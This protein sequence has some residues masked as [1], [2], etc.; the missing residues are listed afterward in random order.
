LI[1][2]KA[3]QPGTVKTRLAATIGAER[4]C[5]VYRRMAEMQ[6]A[7]AKRFT[8]SV[9]IHFAPRSAE[10]EMRNWLGATLEYFTQSD[11]GLGARMAQAVADAFRR[12]AQRVA[13]FG[14]D[15]PALEADRLAMAFA[16]LR[17]DAGREPD[18]AVFG[19]TSDGGNDLLALSRPEPVLFCSIPWSTP[20]TLSAS[21]RAALKAGLKTS[22]LPCENDVDDYG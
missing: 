11:G 9:E 17:P 22:D 16:R 1:F 8:D 15:C 7:E 3:P 20:T 2:L 12:G 13:L 18:D 4:A 10:V 6:V 21:K 19:P 5:A 14:G